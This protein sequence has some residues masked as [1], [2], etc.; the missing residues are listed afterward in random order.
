MKAS[1]QFKMSNQLNLT[2]QLQKAIHLLKLS[3][4]DLKQE[5]QHQVES[6]PLLDAQIAEE[7]NLLE[8][9]NSSLSDE[10]DDFQWSSLYSQSNS[11][12][13]FNENDALIETLNCSKTS[14]KDHLNWQ[15]DLTPLTPRDKIIA[16]SLVDAI[17]NDGYLTLACHEIAKSL[18][19]PDE[20]V[21]T[22]EI[23]TILHYIQRLDPIGCGYRDLAE[24]LIIQLDESD[25]CDNLKYKAQQIISQD[26]ALL[27]KHDIK[28]IKR[29]YSIDD[30]Q[31][32]E[33]LKLIHHLHPHPGRL[34]S[35][36]AP[37][38]IIPDVLVTKIKGKWQANLN[39][40]VLPKLSINDGYAAMLNK[41]NKSAD[42]MF[43]KDNLREAKWFLKGIQSRQDTVLKVAKYIANYQQD[44]FEYG[45]KGMKPLTLNQVANELEMHESTIS[46]VTNQKYL[47]SSKGTFELK[48]F[49]SSHISNNNGEEMS[50]T[51]IR[52]R[53]KALIDKEDIH[54]PYSDKQILFLLEEEGVQISRRTIAKYREELGILPSYERKYL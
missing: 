2:P 47:Y 38:Y 21:E 1:M 28:K 4:L 44:F 31:I 13:T 25:T 7:E 40:E 41:T 48:F 26:M 30:E 14:L 20:M 37:Q 9:E 39:P 23:E 33:I 45:E 19:T 10:F 36:D 46:R 34:I 32:E 3:T 22:R 29:K 18:S 51:A 49:F 8:L 54:K 6:N 17:D 35:T 43:L 16:M 15:I 53:I 52:A 50:S 42:K 5:I 27:A 11:S 24:T 12:R